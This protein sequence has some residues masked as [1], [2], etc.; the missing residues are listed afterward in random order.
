MGDNPDALEACKDD[1]AT[2]DIILATMLFMDD[3]IQAI[4]PALEAR[5]D[6][7]DAMIGMMSAGDVVKLTVLA[8]ST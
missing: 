7:C 1:I 6:R 3:Q 2:G 5:R 4:L 8:S